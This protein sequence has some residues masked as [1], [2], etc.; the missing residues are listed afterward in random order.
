MHHSMSYHAAMVQMKPRVRGSKD[1]H[2]AQRFRP[3]DPAAILLVI[4]Q[5]YRDHMHFWKPPN[6]F[7]QQP[8]SP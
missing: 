5:V 4:W 1:D 8:I 7:S 3:P 6:F 2:H